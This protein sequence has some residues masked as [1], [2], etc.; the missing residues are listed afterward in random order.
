MDHTENKLNMELTS[1]PSPE[2][3]VAR[4]IWWRMLF[5][6]LAWLCIALGV[7]GIFIPGLPTVDFILLAVFFAARGS[8]K[9]HQ[10]LLNHRFIGPIIKE[11]R[12]NRRIPK[13]AKYMST[14]SMSVAAGLMIWI[15]PHP[16]VVYP[17]IACMAVVLIWMWS[18]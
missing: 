9:L 7:L 4:S 12:E 5:I 8:E 16:W 15:I 2:N 11:W 1:A 3:K 13:K 18:K 17:L 6:C 10:W 14:V